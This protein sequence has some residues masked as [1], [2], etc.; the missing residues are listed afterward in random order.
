MSYTKLAKKVFTQMVEGATPSLPQ[1]AINKNEGIVT[2]VNEFVALLA[3]IIQASKDIYNIPD[4][5]VLIPVEQFPRDL[6][7]RLNNGQEAISDTS[8]KQITLVTYSANELPAQISAHGPFATSGIRN[9]KARMIDSYP[10]PLHE[11]YTIVRV[12][13]DIE[14]TFD[15]QVWGLDDKS[16]RDRA[17][18]LRQIIRDNIWY[19]KHK[20]LKDIIWL[21]ATE[22]DRSDKQNVVQFKKESYRVIFTEM[23][24]IREKNIEQILLLIGP[25]L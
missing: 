10:D 18:L 12:G 11:G 17:N 2:S 6:V 16:I 13:K 21:G 24:H 1:E 4:I 22:N 8:K 9:I 25:N 19:L 23:Q 20:G 14:C 7:W 15:L 5:N 3:E